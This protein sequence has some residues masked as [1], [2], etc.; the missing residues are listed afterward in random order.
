MGYIHGVSES[1]F[2][3]YFRIEWHDIE[4]PD[5]HDYTNSMNQISPKKKEEK[6]RNVSLSE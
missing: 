2:L 4:S 5:K 3:L 6:K 1:S